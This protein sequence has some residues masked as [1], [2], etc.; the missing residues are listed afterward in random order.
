MCVCVCR[1]WDIRQLAG[2]LMTLRGGHTQA[3]RRVKC[4]PYHGNMVASCSYDFTVRYMTICVCVCVCMSVC[5][6]PKS[7]YVPCPM[8]SFPMRSKVTDESGS[9][10]CP[11]RLWDIGHPVV[12][13]VE[14]VSHHSEF[15]FGLD[16][17]T[18]AP[19]KVG[20]VKWRF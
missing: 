12:P 14:T 8:T 15:T 16:F 19:G 5:I 4:D 10:T 9:C 20:T 13:L 17:S 6:S 7:A 1:G 18:L 2:P 11:Y 3:V